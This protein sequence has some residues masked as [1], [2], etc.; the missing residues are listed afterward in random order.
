MM[1]HGKYGDW[2]WGSAGHKRFLYIWQEVYSSDNV[3]LAKRKLFILS[4]VPLFEMFLW[5]LVKFM[6][7]FIKKRTG[8]TFINLVKTPKRLVICH[9]WQLLKATTASCWSIFLICFTIKGT[10]NEDL[11]PGDIFRTKVVTDSK[12]CT[13][14]N[15]FLIRQTREIQPTERYWWS[16]YVNSASIYTPEHHFIDIIRLIE[17]K[18]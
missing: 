6:L 14:P 4:C 10:T 2:Y 5:G 18:Y 7:R 12:F 1:V 16:N 3:I 17:L 15:W 11:P 13:L 9:W 8:W